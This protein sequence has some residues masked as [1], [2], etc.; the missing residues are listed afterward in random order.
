MHVGCV[1]ADPSM[2]VSQAAGIMEKKGIGAMPV[3]RRGGGLA[4]MVTDRDLVVRCL[5]TERDP[6]TTLVGDIV[7]GPVICIDRDATLREALSLMEEHMIRRLP[8]LDDQPE[9]IGMISQGDIATRGGASLVGE[10]V[11]AVS[12]GPALQHAL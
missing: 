11:K 7:D 10:L 5:A 1:C 3:L 4:G 8:V 12:T 6:A 2:T 9:P